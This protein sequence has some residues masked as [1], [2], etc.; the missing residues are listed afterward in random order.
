MLTFLRK[1]SSKRSYSSAQGR[2]KNPKDPA[3]Y[4]MRLKGP[5]ILDHIETPAIKQESELE[6][7]LL[8][9]DEVYRPCG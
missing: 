4:S 9:D 8:S 7:P 6:V 2:N 3:T 5:Q 1:S